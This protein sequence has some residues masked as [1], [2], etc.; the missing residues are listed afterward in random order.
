MVTNANDVCT[1]AIWVPR[2]SKTPPP[3]ANPALCACLEDVVELGGVGV[4]ALAQ[5]GPEAALSTAE[6]QELQGGPL[7]PSQRFSPFHPTSG[8]VAD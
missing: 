8:N 6:S 3:C 5:L 7:H 2:S 4:G 1:A